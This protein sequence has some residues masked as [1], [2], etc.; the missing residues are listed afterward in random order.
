MIGIKRVYSKPSA[1]DGM[2]ILVDRVW[3]RGISKQRARIIQWRKDLAPTT[4]LRKWFGHDPARWIEFRRRYR[5]EL[6]QTEMKDELKKLARLSRQRKITL[7]YSAADEEHNQAVVLKELLDEGIGMRILVAL[8]GSEGSS[9]LVAYVG[10]LLRDSPRVKLT[11]L[12]VLNPLP[13][14]LREHGGSEDPDREEQLGRQ[15][16]TDQKA[17]Y[18]REQIF[19]SRILEKARASLERIGFDPARISIKFGYDENVALSILEE[20]QKGRYGTIVVGRKG[21]SGMK[22]LLFGSVSHQVLREATGRVV[23]VVE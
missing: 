20:A 5:A 8:D 15:L 2:R 22:R 23:W 14:V 18:R 19:E 3:P 12:H 4:S 11:L 21:S 10:R 6:A 1:R 7:V 16:R 17:W 13:P 9:R